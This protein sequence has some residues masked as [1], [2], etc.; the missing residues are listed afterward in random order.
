MEVI[1][2]IQGDRDSHLTPLFLVH[3]ISGTALPYLRL[4]LLSDEDRPIY[5]ITNPI[6]CPNPETF[7]FPSSLAGLA[8]FYLDGITRIQPH[9]PY[10][11]GGWSMGGMVAMF[12]AQI[13]QARGE[14]V[15]KVI[16]IDSANPEVFP[17]FTSPEEHRE[18]ARAT[19]EKTVAMVAMELSAG[20]APGSPIP[21]PVMSDGGFDDYALCRQR[22]ASTWRTWS[23][24]SSDCSLFDSPTSTTPGSPALSS[25]SSDYSDNDDDD[26]HDECEEEP[27][28]DNCYEYDDV[29][30][31]ALKAFLGQIKLHVHRGLQLIADVRPGD[32]F[33]P[34]KR[35]NYAVVLIKCRPDGLLLRP[36][37]QHHKAE[38][39]MSVMRERS[40]RWNPGQFRSFETRAFSGDH[41]GAFAPQYVGELSSIL[42]DCLADED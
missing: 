25:I 14:P 34:H 30:P 39:I 29:E 21:S 27:G 40:M 37:H 42:R 36:A 1:T 32:L 6:H 3:A 10:L 23:S 8:A 18:F 17:C 20:S 28:A 9:G 41:D 11:L 24:E 33:T 16:M 5:G 15:S 4:H 12:M 31:P 26:E 2:L 22:R 13:L 19:Y 35:S 38:F 7:K